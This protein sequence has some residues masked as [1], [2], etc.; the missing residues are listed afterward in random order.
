MKKDNF[1]REYNY[2]YATTTMNP[3]L[4][5]RNV[6]KSNFFYEKIFYGITLYETMS[7]FFKKQLSIQLLQLA[8]DPNNK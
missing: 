3:E 2:T 1:H 7:Y 8:F 6:S 4:H 5:Q